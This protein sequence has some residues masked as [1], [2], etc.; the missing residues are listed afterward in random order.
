MRLP[1]NIPGNELARLLHR[2]Y[3]YEIIR[4]RGS[5]MRLS[6]NIAGTT[7]RV[8]IPNQRPLRVGTLNSILSD[9]AE[10]LGISQSELRR[11][12]FDD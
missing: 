9:V 4:Q 10:Y 3:G 6:T 8:T 11:N 1:R 5:H 7:H 2:R 12:L